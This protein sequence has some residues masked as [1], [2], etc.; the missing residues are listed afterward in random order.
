[1]QEQSF[2]EKQT[3]RITQQIF[4]VTTIFMEY[5]TIHGILERTPGGS[6]GGS[7]AALAAGMTP[8]ELR[9]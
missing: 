7:A 6:S 5:L 1:M 9:F 2:L 3:Y 4:K 8:L